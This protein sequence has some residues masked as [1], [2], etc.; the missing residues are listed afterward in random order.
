LGSGQWG[1]PV[2]NDCTQRRL[3]KKKKKKTT[4]TTLLRGIGG[5]VV[6]SKFYFNAVFQQGAI[7]K[8]LAFM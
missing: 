6:V 7:H 3:K 8:E 2:Q 1:I 5:W 4:A